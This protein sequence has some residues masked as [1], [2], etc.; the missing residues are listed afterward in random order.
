MTVRFSRTANELQRLQFLRQG[1]ALQEG[2]SKLT[3]ASGRRRLVAL[4]DV[5]VSPQPAKARRSKL[6]IAAS[7]SSKLLVAILTF[8]LVFTH[9]A[10]F[11]TQYQSAVQV[12]LLCFPLLTQRYSIGGCL[13]WNSS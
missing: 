11:G 6:A 7:V 1:C 4:L 8:S 2:F 13:K 12:S 9:P 10:F 5:A 3:P